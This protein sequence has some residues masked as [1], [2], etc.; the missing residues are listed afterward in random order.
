MAWKRRPRYA[1]WFDMAVRRGLEA[2]G[3]ISPA[4]AVEVRFG[5]GAKVKKRVVVW[6]RVSKKVLREDAMA[7]MMV[8]RVVLGER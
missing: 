7:D 6:L 5:K 8:V 1:K 2:W 4:S 3:R